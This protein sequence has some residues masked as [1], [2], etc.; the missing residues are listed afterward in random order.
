[1]QKSD[2]LHTTLIAKEKR[3]EKRKRKKEGKIFGTEPRLSGMDA[4]G[5]K[6]RKGRKGQ[7]SL[8]FIFLREKK[9]KREREEKERPNSYLT[10]VQSTTPRFPQRL[11]RGEKK[12]GR[13]NK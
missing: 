10:E 5:G 7:S 2:S 11:D 4:K 13:F 12:K 6:R 1:M 8:S 3:E 9:K